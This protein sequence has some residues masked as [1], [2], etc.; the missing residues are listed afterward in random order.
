MIYYQIQ[1]DGQ[2]I[3]IVQM[4]KTYLISNLFKFV[5]SQIWQFK[6]F[7]YLFYCLYKWLCSYMFLLV[8]CPSYLHS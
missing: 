3:F 7:G 1:I 2:F 8:G 4:A 5:Q 6:F